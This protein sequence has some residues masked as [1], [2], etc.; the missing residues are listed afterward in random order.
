VVAVGGRPERGRR[1]DAA[2]GEVAG[3][4]VLLA[5]NGY[6]TGQT[7]NVNGGWYMT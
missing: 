1:G 7:V 3:V 4:A 5:S 6:L 2:S